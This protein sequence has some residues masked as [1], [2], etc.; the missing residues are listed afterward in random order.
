MTPTAAGAACLALRRAGVPD[1]NT[2][3]PRLLALLAQGVTPVELAEAAQS[4]AEGK[5]KFAYVLATVEGRRRDAAAIGT[6]P[7]P[8]P[9]ANRQQALED[10]NR[11][12]GDAWADAHTEDSHAT[13]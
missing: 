11:T 12:V 1:C 4:L 3:H 5:R 10:S 7:P 8:A 9:R 2:S 6:L 13:R